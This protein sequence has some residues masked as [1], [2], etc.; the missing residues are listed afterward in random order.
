M[1][2]DVEFA[3]KE[4]DWISGANLQGHCWIKLPLFKIFIQNAFRL[5]VC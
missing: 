2:W 5:Q 1:E 3:M 4:D